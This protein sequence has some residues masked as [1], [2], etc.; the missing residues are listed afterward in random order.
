MTTA[1][2]VRDGCELA[3]AVDIESIPSDD[4]L[5]YAHG[6]ARAMW[7]DDPTKGHLSILKGLSA[8]FM[9]GFRHGS[10]VRDGESP[11]PA[12]VSDEAETTLRTGSR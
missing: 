10:R 9:M 6:F 7:N 1:D 12:W 2:L 5:S 4:P 3:L 11:M 8:A